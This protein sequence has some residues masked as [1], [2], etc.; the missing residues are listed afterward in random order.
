MKIRLQMLQRNQLK[1][2]MPINIYHTM[3]HIFPYFLPI[4][5]QVIRDEVDF[6]NYTRA[7]IIAMV[8]IVVMIPSTIVL[9]V[10]GDKIRKWRLELIAVGFLII[11]SH[12]F[13]IYVA[14]SFAVL[15][16][17][18][19]VA[20]LGA[21]IFHPIALPLLSQEFGADRNVA[22]SINLIFGT[23]GSITTPIMT[24]GLSSWLGW[25]TTTLILGIF[26]LLVA[27]ILITT[28]LLTKKYLVYTPQKEI[29]TNEDVIPI[30]TKEKKRTRKPLLSFISGPFIALVFVLVLRSGIFR[31]MNTFTSFIFEDRFGAS[32][33]HSAMI[34]SLVLGSGG[35][36][37][38]ISGFVSKKKGSLKTFL[39]SMGA[40]VLASIAVVIFVG[41]MD[42]ANLQI[43]T[44]LLVVA[45][46]LFVFLS[47]S[48]Y[49]SNPSANSLQAEIIPLEILGT[50]YGIIV[51]IMTGFSA[52]IPVI[53]GAIVDQGYSLPYE[54]LLPIILSLIPFLLLIYMKSKIGLKTPDQVE[55]E[56]LE[57]TNALL[58]AIEKRKKGETLNQK[59]Q[60]ESNSQP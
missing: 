7:G 30:D 42:L 57:K 34:M 49:F 14:N 44:G 20:G 43:N 27:P 41:T 4:L 32:E 16:I 59:I 1:L 33:F 21:S 23:F 38:L 24:I 9:G 60:T 22:H 37:A 54:Y 47:T 36:A 55:K 46:L 2:L 12:T 26:G 48:F 8:S 5:C 10:V 56:R 18:A 53:F 3:A 28:S 51:A 6:L 35:V 17:A 19:V 50:V 13:I 11:V 25:R 39:F 29:I 58:E 31:I 40:T 52:V 45:I 15:I